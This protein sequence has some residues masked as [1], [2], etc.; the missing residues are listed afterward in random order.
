MSESYEQNRFCIDSE[1]GGIAEPEEDLAEG[2]LLRYWVCKACD[3]EFGHVTVQDEGAAGTC[4]LGVPEGVRRA[5]SLE[6]ASKGVFIGQIGR[7]PQ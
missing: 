2:G 4:A 3:T 1:C 6:P 7:R 5:A